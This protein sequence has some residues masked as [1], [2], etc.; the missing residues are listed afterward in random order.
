MAAISLIENA[1]GQPTLCDLFCKM[2]SKINIATNAQVIRENCLFR[3]GMLSRAAPPLIDR[4]RDRTQGPQD[5]CYWANIAI[6]DSTTHWKQ[7]V[8]A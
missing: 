4:D 6:Q 7:A 5:S 8:V 2:Y 1:W 3:H